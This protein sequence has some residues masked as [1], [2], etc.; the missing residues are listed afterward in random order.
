MLFAVAEIVVLRL[1]FD[2]FSANRKR[3][4]HVRVC[5]CVCVCV[6]YAP[7]VARSLMIIPFLSGK[8]KTIRLLH[9]DPANVILFFAFLYLTKK[10]SI[11][12]DVD[13]D[14]YAIKRKY[15]KVLS[16]FK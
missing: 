7:S 1:L 12:G 8:E 14:S 6:D 11:H 13:N 4:K 15:S 9:I 10:K 3:F 16:K 5:L 2:L